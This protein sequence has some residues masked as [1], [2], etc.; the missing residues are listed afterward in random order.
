[1]SVESLRVKQKSLRSSFTMCCTS[2]EE[3]LKKDTTLSDLYALQRQIMDKFTRLDTVQEHILE[4]LLSD[5][6]VSSEYEEDFTKAEKYRDKMNQLSAELENTD[7]TSEGLDSGR[8]LDRLMTF[9]RKEVESEEMILLARTGL[10]SPQRQKSKATV[11]EPFLATSAAL[12]N[13]KGGRSGKQKFCLFCSQCNHWSS[14]CL[15][16][17]KLSLNDKKS[18]LIRNRACFRCLSKGH[19]ARSCRLKMLKCMNCDDKSHHTLL[20][21]KNE[22]F[23]L[24]NETVGATISNSLANQSLITNVYLQTIVLKLCYNNNEMVLRCL[25]DNGS[26]KSYLT[27]RVIDHLN[28]KPV[29]K[30]TIVHGLFGGRETA[31]RKHLLYNVIIKSIDDSFSCQIKVL[32]ENKICGYLPKVNDLQVLSEIKEKSILVPDLCNSVNEIDMLLGADVISVILSG[33]TIKLKSGLIAIGTMLG[34]TL[35]GKT[36]QIVN[37]NNEISVPTTRER[38]LKLDVVPLDA[39]APKIPS[40][41]VDVSESTMIPVDAPPNRPKLSRYGRT[42]RRP[43]RLSVFN[44][45]AVFESE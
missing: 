22:E 31:P 44:N 45:T 34:F 36:S 30:Q 28:L 15:I 41:N 5:D 37:D 27:Q 18:I 19:N 4:L 8:T 42:I 12:V 17:K 26:Q 32:S 3:A 2:I 40:A 7:P 33:R 13:T 24:K 1:M 43:K 10:G 6:L 29:S 11:E 35:M 23:D 39:D 20:C 9:L 25:L 16:G 14:D 21:N 38:Q